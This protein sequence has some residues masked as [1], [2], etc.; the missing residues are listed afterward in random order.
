[1]TDI[2]W[3]KVETIIDE[4]LEL[5]EGKR[6]SFIQQ[7]CEGNPKLKGEVTSL[8]ESIF[9][10]EG[11]LENPQ[12]YMEDFYHEMSSDIEL[13]S[14]HD[15]LTGRVIGAYTIKEQIGEGGM[16][17]V[18]LAE[19]TDGQFEHQVAIKIIQHGKATRE[20]IQRF[21]RERNILAGLNHPGI[22]KLF[23]G[24]IT[25]DGFHYLIMEY[26]EG[27]P[28]DEY[29]QQND[30]TV[31]QKVSLFKQIL[32][33]VRHA[34]ENLVI[35]RDLKPSNI[36]VDPEG[37]A[38]ILDFGIS[39]LLE[40]ETSADLTQTGARLLTPRYAAPEQITESN[41]TTATDLY[42]LGIVFYRLL[43]GSHP[44]ELDTL[45]R[46]Q[47]EQ[48]V[49]KEAPP[50]PSDKVSSPAFKKQ[51]R[52]DLDAITLKAIRKEA[53]QRYRVANE[54]LE[55]LN[56]YQQGLP[57]SAHSDTLKYRSKKFLARH[58]ISL[59]TGIGFLLLL[60]GFGA[61]HTTRITQERNSARLE[62]ER[63][64]QIKNL[65]SEILQQQD[66][67]SQPD[68]DITLAEVLDRGTGDIQRGLEDQPE[69][70]AELLGLLGENYISLGDFDKG[71]NL[72]RE[73]LALYSPSQPQSAQQTYINNLSRI[74]R[75]YGRT[76]R[77]QQAEA[78]Y[79][80]A[81]Q[82][83]QYEYGENTSYAAPFYGSLA[84]VYRE[85]GKL[86]KTEEYYKRAIEL[87]DS[88]HKLSLATSLGNLAIA[89]RD[90]QKYDK[91]VKLHKQSIKLEHEVHDSLHPDIASGYNHLAF[92]YQQ[93]GNYPKADSLHQIA[94]GMRRKLFPPDHHHIASSLVRLG[95]LKIKQL[96][97]REAE[98]L[99][100][101]GY[102]I[103]RDKLP[104]DHW[105]VISAKGGLAVSRAMQGEFEK[106]VPIVEEAYEKF[107]DKFGEDDWRSLEA[108]SA[109]SNLFQIWGKPDKARFYSAK[110]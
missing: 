4:A 26:I 20:N 8:L 23:D 105:Q 74:G 59:L 99:L 53:G 109:L 91:A 18:Y 16:G 33:A 82:L 51:L 108:A 77:F 76:G 86:L 41:I 19:R 81:L 98:N 68:R 37:N 75:V 58:K 87:A 3:D 27:T 60:I 29:C 72:L 102:Q 61:L 30:C 71:E 70:K 10:S 11:W 14:P 50:K 79:L 31:E 65:F 6:N 63:A 57:V 34:H 17:A 49:L 47:M 67:F 92:T 25:E 42:A 46:Y 24:G 84:S 55:D 104:N 48:K 12:T 107:C 85:Q 83:I 35:H 106:N 95:L 45:S 66:P 93:M 90:Q 21:R 62:A 88:T 101:E 78:A 69:V 13:L 39:K 5:P 43:S 40:E 80:E 97:T 64:T 54:F 15:S 1:M 22:A 94:L 36:L 100:E 32:E 73:A 2:N 56:H 7:Q 96:H 110:H 9:H 38:K 52:G 44:Y 28:I 103:L 89:Y